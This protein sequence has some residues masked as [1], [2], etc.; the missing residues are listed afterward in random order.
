MNL[1]PA[2]RNVL[3]TLLVMG[4]G[5]TALD[6]GFA[7]TIHSTTAHALERRGLVSISPKGD[8]DLTKDGRK[9]AKEIQ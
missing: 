5:T 8:V 1:S 6:G 9:A 4:R 3:R 2:Q 7:G